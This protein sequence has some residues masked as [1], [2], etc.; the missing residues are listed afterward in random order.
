MAG[1]DLNFSLKL[2]IK[3]PMPKLDGDTSK[4]LEKHE[5]A[6]RAGVEAAAIPV[7]SALRK[8][9]Q[10]AM[11][12][13]VWGPF[14]PSEPYMGAAG[15]LKGRD[16][17]RTLVETG[18]LYRSLAIRPQINDRGV[19]VL[20]EYNSPYAAFTHYGGWI[21]PWGNPNAA[22]KYITPRPWISA[23]FD[24]T[25]GFDKFNPA[26][27]IQEEMAKTWKTRFG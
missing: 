2:E 1:K 9:L 22:S 24:G 13:N 19:Q 7:T 23:V 5:D 14:F 16:A 20:G 18:E 21:Q 26:P 15:G 27:I 11:R 3:P 4:I 12:S 25:H 6:I 10:D 17:T 8:V